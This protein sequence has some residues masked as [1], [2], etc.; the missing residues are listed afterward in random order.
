MICQI[1]GSGVGRDHRFCFS[2]GTRL[3][4]EAPPLGTEGYSSNQLPVNRVKRH[5][6]RLGCLWCVFGAYQLVRGVLGFMVLRGFSFYHVRSEFILMLPAWA[7]ALMPVLLTITAAGT[8]LALTT[9]YALLTRRPWAR[10]LA[11]VAAILLMIQAPFG[12]ALAIYTLWVLFSATSA[13]EYEAE[14]H[15]SPKTAGMMAPPP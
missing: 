3:T 14:A 4:L 15:A 2:C 11:L 13:L 7:L 12:L 5:L 9:G 6:G 1:C 8:A 10:T